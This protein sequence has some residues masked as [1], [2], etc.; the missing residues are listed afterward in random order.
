LQFSIN[1][2]KQNLTGDH[3]QLEGLSEFDRTETLL[4]AAVA[5][6]KAKNEVCIT[7]LALFNLTH[8]LIRKFSS[9]KQK[10][11]WQLS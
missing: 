5:G 1:N 3:L 11:G 9:L 2:C 4:R 6:E 7:K 8:D 10:K